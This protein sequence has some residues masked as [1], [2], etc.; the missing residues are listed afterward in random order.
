MMCSMSAQQ[1]R[2]LQ[3]T[4]PGAQFIEGSNAGNAA[5]DQANRAQHSPAIESPLSSS[6]QSVANA[7]YRYDLSV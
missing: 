7:V 5:T 6:E 4:I 3:Q 1:I 2:H